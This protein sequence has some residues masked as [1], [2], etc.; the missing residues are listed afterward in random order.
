MFTLHCGF[1]LLV[2]LL[3]CLILLLWAVAPMAIVV[4]A[5]MAMVTIAV[6]FAPIAMATGN[7]VDISPIAT[8]V[9]AIGCFGYNYYRCC[10]G[11]GSYCCCL[12]M[13]Q[14][15]KMN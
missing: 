4:Y 15:D 8:H 2:M 5:T 13:K 1:W 7:A 12:M 3:I 9:L 10:F 11:Y 6:D 14:V